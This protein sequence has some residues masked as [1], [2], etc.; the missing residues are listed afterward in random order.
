[1]GNRGHKA[2]REPES[3]AVSEATSLLQRSDKSYRS[4]RSTGRLTT[5][6]STLEEQALSLHIEGESECV[7]TYKAS[8]LG[9]WRA[10]LY[11]AGTIWTKRTFWQNQACLMLI[12]TGSAF[13][14]W[15]LCPYVKQGMLSQFD[16]VAKLFAVLVTF[17]LGYFLKSSVDRWSRTV[18]G[19]LL[20]GNSV[21]N[22]M[23]QM[24][25]LGAPK[26]R[27]KQIARYGLLSLKFL[28]L[29]LRLRLIET[30][31][32]KEEAQEE[33]WSAA[34]ADRSLLE[35][36]EITLRKGPR[37]DN[38]IL[39]WIWISMCISRMA[40]DGEVPP[41]VSATFARLLDLTTQAQEGIRQ[42]RVSIE[43][44]TPFVYVHT[45]ALL[46]HMN[47]IVCAINFGFSFASHLLQ[48]LERHEV[49]HPFA[50]ILYEEEA[51]A[52]TTAN[53]VQ[54]IILS[55]ITCCLAP[56]MYQAFLQIG[57]SLSQ[58]F[59]TK[60]GTIPTIQLVCQL[61]QDLEHS[62]VIAR[63]PPNF[64]KPCFKNPT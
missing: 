14:S 2:A 39:M 58:P 64:K 10:F 54:A 11:V 17:L 38:A 25:G 53:D 24:H 15:F 50:H 35:P 63:E 41:M 8:N 42:V 26:K 62:E 60:V 18:D 34:R 13:V 48:I 46:V 4:T 21:R 36:E 28:I 3:P 44:Q 59:G 31:Y 30:Q 19:F 12:A 51:G 33:Y 6:C 57:L 61:K 23:V 45:L 27:R 9:T 32:G 5:V 16:A 43:V 20:M 56:L 49:I 47:N 52:S 55:Y 7:G 40:Q 29:E 22:L 1:M 37:Q